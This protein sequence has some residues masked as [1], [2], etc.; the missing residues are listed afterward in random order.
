MRKPLEL[1]RDKEHQED[2]SMISSQSLKNEIHKIDQ[3]IE[4]IQG[5]LAQELDMMAK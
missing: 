4:N 1:S 2:N 3:E 5:I